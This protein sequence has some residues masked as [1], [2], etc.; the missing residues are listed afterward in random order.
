MHSGGMIGGFAG[1]KPDEVPIIGQK[2]ERV[3]SRDQVKAGV[4]GGGATSFNPSITINMSGQSSGNGQQTAQQIGAE[5]YAA[6]M[7]AY[8]RNR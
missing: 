7:R 6:S 8:R 2:G 4:G 3:L 1:L 5:V